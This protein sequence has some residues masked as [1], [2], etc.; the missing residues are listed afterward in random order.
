MKRRQTFS[1][2]LFAF[3]L[4]LPILI[5][6]GGCVYE[7]RDDHRDEWRA[8]ERRDHHD[9]DDHHEDRDDDRRR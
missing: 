8:H 3:V 1:Q 7:D 2:A 6:A 4:A 5:A 9:F